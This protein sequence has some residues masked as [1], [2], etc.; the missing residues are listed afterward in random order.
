M[1]AT[2][3][4]GTYDVRGTTTNGRSGTWLSRLGVYVGVVD[5]DD[6]QAAGGRA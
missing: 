1:F 2:R 6:N 3:K 5:G 4:E